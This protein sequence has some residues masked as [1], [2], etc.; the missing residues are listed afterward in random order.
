[1]Y[2][3]SSAELPYRMGEHVGRQGTHRMLDLPPK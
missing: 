1:M 3:I 2:D